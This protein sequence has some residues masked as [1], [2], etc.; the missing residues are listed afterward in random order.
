[1]VKDPPGLTVYDIAATLTSLD[2]TEGAA[3]DAA[4]NLYFSTNG[5]RIL[6]VTASTGVLTVV[7]GAGNEGFSGDGGLAT[8]AALYYPRGIALDKFG[9]ILVADQFNHR[10]RKITVS[11]GIITT[12]AGDGMGNYPGADNVAATSSSLEIPTDVAVDTFGNIY[13]ADQGTDRVRKITASTGIITTYGDRY[14]IPVSGLANS[15]SPTGVTVDK[16]GNVF[17]SDARNNRIYKITA[18]TGFL[19]VVA[20][21]YGWNA[22]Y[23]GDDIPASTATLNYPSAITVDALGN[24]FFVDLNNHRIRKITA[25]TGIIST[26]A[27]ISSIILSISPV[28]P[29]LSNAYDSDGKNATSVSFCFPRGIAIDTAGSLYLCDRRLVRKVTF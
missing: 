28:N 4:G 3:I 19:S 15:I 13:I 5:H 6:K 23:N 20:G 14:G 8:S 2:W 26:V 22:D 1:M 17:I 7:A 27:G 10:I 11:T 12:V 21:Q 18:S 25:S 29:C 24:I 16:A 9:N